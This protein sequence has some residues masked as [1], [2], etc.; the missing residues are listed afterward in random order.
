MARD[1]V[2]LWLTS[3]IEV[4]VVPIASRTARTARHHLFHPSVAAPGEGAS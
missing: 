3:Y 2:Q 4:D 1:G